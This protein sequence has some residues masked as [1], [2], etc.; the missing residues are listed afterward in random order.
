MRFSFERTWQVSREPPRDSRLLMTLPGVS[1]F[2]RGLS[3]VLEALLFEGLG[4][5]GN[6]GMGRGR[7][8]FRR[9][10]NLGRLRPLPGDQ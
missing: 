5:P 10:Q 3:E 1:R 2:L 4:L 7:R 6:D 8:F 9:E